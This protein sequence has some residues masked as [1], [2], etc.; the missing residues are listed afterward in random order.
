[1]HIVPRLTQQLFQSAIYVRIGESD[2]QIPRDLFNNPGDSPN[3]FSLGFAIFFMAPSEVF[4]SLNQRTLLRPPSI[5]PPHVPGRS[6]RIFHDLLQFLKGY[7]LHIRDDQHRADLLRDARYFHLKGLEQK[8]IAHDIS[9]NPVRQKTEITIR[10]EDIR[11]SG[12]SFTSDSPNSSSAS[13]TS[14]SFSVPS[15]EPSDSTSST[16]S[17]LRTGGWIL[18]QRPFVDDTAYELVIEIGNDSTTL[19]ELKP[20]PTADQA[21]TG[22]AEFHGQ[23]KARVTSLFQVISNKMNLPVDNQL[24][25]MM[26]ERGAG[27]ASLPVS[28]ANSGI[29]EHKVKVR[30]GDDA[31]VVLD[32][33]TWPMT[34]ERLWV[35]K[36]WTVS[37]GLWRIRMQPTKRGRMEAVLCAIKLEAF[38]SERGRNA[39]RTFL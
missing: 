38:T 2:F 9:Y 13:S 7:P 28:P 18:Y 15:L 34:E 30:I 6:A 37:K 23:N 1:M 19:V 21:T 25:V 33:K 11:Q 26:L 14:A 16:S 31:A 27:I 8:L 17:S 24:G 29:S 4:P 22:R 36:E 12:I 3:F 5:L 32:G 10:L 35:E 39:K 20:S